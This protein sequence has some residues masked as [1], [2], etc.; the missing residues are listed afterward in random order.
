MPKSALFQLHFRPARA[1]VLA[2][3]AVIWLSLGTGCG[4]SGHVESIDD[5]AK[6]MA[7]QVELMNKQFAATNQQIALANQ[8]LTITN[9]QFALAN[10]ELAAD[11]AYLK[12]LTEQIEMMSQAVVAVQKLSE[13]AFNFIVQRLLTPSPAPTPPPG[14]EDLFPSPAPTPRPSPSTSNLPSPSPTSGAQS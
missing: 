11:R 13:N 8:Q 5:S 7:D 6:R 3:A 14:L 1:F 2:A 9:Q 4:V 10:Q 12:V